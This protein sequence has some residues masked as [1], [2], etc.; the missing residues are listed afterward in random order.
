MSAMMKTTSES[1]N[2]NDRTSQKVRGHFVRTASEKRY[3]LCKNNTIIDMNF[4]TV[5]YSLADSSIIIPTVTD[6]VN[7]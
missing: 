5:H 3:F 6:A 4:L 7:E 1:S 2:L